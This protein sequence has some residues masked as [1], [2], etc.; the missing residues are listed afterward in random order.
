[1]DSNINIYVSLYNSF[2]EI[3]FGVFYVPDIILSVGGIVDHY[4]FCF[5]RTNILEW[6]SSK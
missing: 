1:M 2:N 5:Y 3:L 4:N 6:R